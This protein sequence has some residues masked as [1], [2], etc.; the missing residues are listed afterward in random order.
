MGAQRHAGPLERLVAAA[1]PGGG[2]A[3]DA[4]DPPALRV[5][6]GFKGGR[7]AIGRPAQ[8][9]EGDPALAGSTLSQPAVR[10]GPDLPRPLVQRRALA[11]KRPLGD[12]GERG[13]VR[14]PC[15][16][17]RSE[18]RGG[19]SPPL[20]RIDRRASTQSSGTASSAAWVGVEQQTAATSS[21]RVESRWCPTALITG[22]RSIATVRQRVSSQKAQRSA[23]LPPP[24]ETTIASTSA[25]RRGR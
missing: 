1:E 16:R 5:A 17:P 20:R 24:L 23:R 7:G 3:P 4:L 10:R 6:L 15:R 8:D 11:A 22:T 12:A 2:G 9:D 14:G 13:E 21:I 19:G 25:T 18:R